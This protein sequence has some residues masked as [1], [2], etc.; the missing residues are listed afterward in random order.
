MDLPSEVEWILSVHRAYYKLKIMFV[1][2]RDI[3]HIV[4]I[5]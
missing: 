2:T 1:F 4:L 5:V 3:F